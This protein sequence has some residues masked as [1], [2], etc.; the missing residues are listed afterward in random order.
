MRLF[1]FLVWLLP[2]FTPICR[3]DGIFHDWFDAAMTVVGDT[4]GL[5]NVIRE[6][7]T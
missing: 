7:P 4:D 2:N 3:S 5:S 6:L 1:Q